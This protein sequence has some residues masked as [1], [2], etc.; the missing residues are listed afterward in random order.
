MPRQPPAPPRQLSYGVVEYQDGS[1]NAR[2]VCWGPLSEAALAE[3]CAVAR[4]HGCRPTSTAGWLTKSISQS[5]PK[6]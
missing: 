4:K 6:E 1:G 5:E 3:L 2:F